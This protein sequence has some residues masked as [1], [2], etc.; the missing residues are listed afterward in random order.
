MDQNTLH[1]CYDEYMTTNQ[2]KPWFFETFN[3]IFR[4]IFPENF[5]EFPQVVQKI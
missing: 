1:C 2:Q 3:I 4:H 5:I